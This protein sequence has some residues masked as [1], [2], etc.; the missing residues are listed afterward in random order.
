ML[1]RATEQITPVLPAVGTTTTT[2]FARD[3][4]EF[5]THSRATPAKNGTSPHDG[6]AVLTLIR[7]GQPVATFN[8]FEEDPQ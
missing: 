3:P 8:T 7:G 5:T 6:G 2:R 1:Q 4:G